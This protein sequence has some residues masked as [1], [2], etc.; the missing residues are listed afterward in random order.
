VSIKLNVF[1]V[2]KFIKMINSVV[3]GLIDNKIQ[4]GHHFK[5]K[6]A[7][8]SYHPHYSDYSGVKCYVFG[9]KEFIIM[10]N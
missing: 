2:K 6:T 5:G 7:E 8:L 1:R 3:E 4:D 10:I 9:V